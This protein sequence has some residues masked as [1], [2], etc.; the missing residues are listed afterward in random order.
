MDTMTRISVVLPTLERPEAIYNL[1]RHLEHQTVAPFEIVVIDQSAG[2]D[3]RVAAYAAEHPLVRHH[4]IPVKGLPN[5]RNVGVARSRGD[6]VVFLDDDSIPHADLVR[7]HA[8]AYADPTV[9][10]VG[11]QVRGGYDAA[12]G[13]IGTFRESD[14]RVVRNFGASRRCAVDHL[15]GG[16]MSFRREVFEKVGGF[17]LRFG[18]SAIGEETDFCLRARRAGFRFVFEPRAS[19]EHLHLP[20]GGCRA[21]SFENWLYWHSHNTVLFALR[22]ARLAMLPF[23]L[24]KRTLRLGLF[25]IEHGS[26]AL[27]AVGLQGFARGIATWRAGR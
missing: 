13:A 15:P 9:A 4:R 3:A 10:G 19:L 12:D 17:D 27:I 23:F 5:A 11:G 26:P 18:G 14:G 22:H 25:A 16:N 7:F 20:T 6:V 24:I 21:P 2:V 1:L 8:E